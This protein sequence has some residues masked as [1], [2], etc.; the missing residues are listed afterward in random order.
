MI[1]ADIQ[2]LG[3]QLLPMNKRGANL[4]DIVR[5]MLSPLSSMYDDVDAHRSEIITRANT[6]SQVA[7]LEAYMRRKIGNDGVWIEDS[8]ED[9]SPVVYRRE[10]ALDSIVLYRNGETSGVD[11]RVVIFR[12]EE[13]VDEPS[14]FLILVSDYNYEPYRGALAKMADEFKFADKTYRID[15]KID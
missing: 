11:V 7:S 1:R 5:V 15:I 2:V 6:T 9:V 3:H 8:G 12:T 4:L 13:T 14:D 10:D